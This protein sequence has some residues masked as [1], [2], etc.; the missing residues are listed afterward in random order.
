MLNDTMGHATSNPAC[1]GLYR[2]NTQFIGQP[3]GKGDEEI[4]DLKDMSFKSKFR[5]CLD[6]IR[7]NQLQK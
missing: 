1:R 6:A 4:I 3:Y 2:T 5:P 7:T